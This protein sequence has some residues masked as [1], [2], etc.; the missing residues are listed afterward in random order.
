VSWFPVAESLAAID[1]MLVGL[2]DRTGHASESRRVAAAIDDRVRAIRQAV[3]SE[4]RPRVLMVVGA[5]PV[6]AAGPSSF[7]DEL[8]RLAGATNVVD[9]GPAWP[10]LGF[11]RIVELDPDVVIDSSGGAEGVVHVTARAAGWSGIRAV[12]DG[13]VIVL[14]DERVLRPGPRIA[15]GLAVLARSLHPAAPV[16]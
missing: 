13:R 1:E 14:H 9:V 3:A 2:G 12:R 11:E 15:E 6:V 5:A 10:T 8:L 4:P 16:P 7:V